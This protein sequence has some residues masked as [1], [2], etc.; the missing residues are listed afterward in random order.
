MTLLDLHRGDNPSP[1][2][3]DPW[4]R[5]M[6]HRLVTLLKQRTTTGANGHLG[7]LASDR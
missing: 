5:L 3:R 1:L 7:T 4:R 2:E 6:R